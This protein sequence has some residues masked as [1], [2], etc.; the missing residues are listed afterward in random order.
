MI[1]ERTK[2]ALAVKRSQGVRIGAE[3]RIVGDLA[4][5]IR[6]QRRRG[7]TLQ[8][9]CDRLNGDGVPTANGGQL[10]RPTSLRVVLRGVEPR[11]VSVARRT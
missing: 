8:A 11:R 9:I 10:W 6:A 5:W 1:S 4:K 7:V 3:P 2:A